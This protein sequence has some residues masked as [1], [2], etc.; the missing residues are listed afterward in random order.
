MDS[1]DDEFM[2]LEKI[3]ID[4][5]LVTNETG[6]KQAFRDKENG[7]LLWRD[8]HRSKSLVDKILEVLLRCSHQEDISLMSSHRTQ[9]SE[10]HTI[11]NFTFTSTCVHCYREDYVLG[12]MTS[13]EVLLGK[14]LEDWKSLERTCGFCL[15]NVCFAY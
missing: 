3:P 4:K 13:K 10:L 14:E 7:H 9:E 15:S 6:L 12:A 2:D 5:Q 11:V 1:L 8:G